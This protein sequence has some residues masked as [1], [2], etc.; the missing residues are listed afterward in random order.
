MTDWAA[1]NR[2]TCRCTSPAFWPSPRPAAG[3]RRVCSHCLKFEALPEPGPVT[4]EHLKSQE[5]QGN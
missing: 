2:N 5:D 1:I 3:Q 4:K